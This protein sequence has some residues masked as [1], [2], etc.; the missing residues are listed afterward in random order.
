[1]HI[2]LDALGG[3][4]G[5][6]FVAALLDAAPDHEDTVRRIV[7]RAVST[8]C[9]S[10]PH[11][12]RIL[13]GRRFSVDAASA[14]GHHHHAHWADIRTRLEAGLDQPVGRHAIGIFAVLADAE[15]RVHGVA[16]DDV[17]FHEVGAVDSIADIVAAA[18]LI[19]ALGVTSTSVSPLPLGSGRIRTAHGVMPVPAPAV[20]LLLEGFDTLDDGIEGERITPTGAAILRYLA[21]SPRIG[22]AARRLVATGY[23]FGTR[24][25]PGIA[26]CLR[27]TLFAAGAASTAIPHRTL[28]VI[29]FEIDDQSAED[30]ASGLERLRATEGVH[31]VLQIP[32]IGKKGRMATQIQVLADAGH[33]DAIVEACFEETTTIGLRIQH[34]EA[35]ALSRRIACVPVDGHDVRVKLVAR[36]G[37]QTA[38]PEA[39]DVATAGGMDARARRRAAALLAATRTDR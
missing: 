37:G 25:L 6:M 19:E 10:S 38:K 14:P 15:A 20:S 27:A 5:D 23:G 3:V 12:D 33:A 1:M 8:T 18:V 39:D 21:P 16:P 26:N 9:G 35:R 36:P 24:T 29:A 7:E 11:T 13:T 17:A 4:A 28:S 22:S 32:A 2:H 34:V 31:D 30:L